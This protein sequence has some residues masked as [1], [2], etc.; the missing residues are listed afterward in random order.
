MGLLPPHYK[1]KGFG[2]LVNQPEI[3]RLEIKAE[4]G[5][6]NVGFEAQSNSYTK[7]ESLLPFKRK[8][9]VDENMVVRV[10]SA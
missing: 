9:F 7:A 1:G 10:I 8:L 5:C 6:E 2:L 3:D 4:D